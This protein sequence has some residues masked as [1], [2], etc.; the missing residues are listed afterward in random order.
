MHFVILF[1]EPSE[2][3]SAHGPFGKRGR[4]FLIVLRHVF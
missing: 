3:S 1:L 2:G 4:Y